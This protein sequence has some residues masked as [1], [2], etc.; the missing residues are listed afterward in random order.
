MAVSVAPARGAPAAAGAPRPAAYLTIPAILIAAAMLMPAAYLV[1]RT[2][3]GGTVALS[4]LLRT[5]TLAVLGQTAALATVVTAATTLISIPMAWLTVRTDL[6]LKRLW[7]VLT[8]LPLVIPSYVGG[9]VMIAAFGPRG[10]LQSLLSPLGVERL[11]EIYG[12]PGAALALT[13][14]SYP[15]VLLN[16]RGVLKGMDSSFEDASRSLGH[17]PR[18]T[19]FRVTLPHLKPAAAAGALLVALYTLSDFGAVSLL[20]F[21]SFT[22]QIYVQYQASFDRTLAA[23]FALVLVVLTVLVLGAE[24]RFR[25]KSRYYRTG[26]G[27]TKPAETVKLGRWKWPGLLFCGSV[28]FFALVVPISILFYWLFQGLLNLTPLQFAWQTALN[29]A[30][31]SALAALA[32]VPLA[33]PVAILAVRYPGRT[34]GLLERVSYMGFA[35]P[36][37]VI[38][39]SLVFFGI[40]FVPFLYQTLAMLVFAYLMLFL[41]QAVGSVRAAL[42]QVNPRLEEAGRSLGHSFPAVLARITLPLIRPGLL[43]GAALV[44]LTVMKELPATLVL[45]PIGF[46]TLATEV[47]NAT[48]EGL[49]A[50]AAAPAL[51]LIAVSSAAIALLIFQ[52]SK[53]EARNPG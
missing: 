34:S 50:Q 52:E 11:P 27:S 4:L 48:S 3:G 16:I 15:Y 40:R 38:A 17:G 35:L 26:S 21:D 25:T 28:V 5:R 44:F 41:P 30:L 45:S 42:L 18:V 43:G 47:W 33:F 53:S 31:A 9:F 29:S 14:F 23:V 51:L 19:F 6:P 20:Q 2:F 12:F 22:R 8:V 36:G 32:T 39:L 49:F 1:I 24:G 46:D 10:L 13:L 7:S 37:I